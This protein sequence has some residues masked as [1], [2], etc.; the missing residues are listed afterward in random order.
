MLTKPGCPPLLGVSVKS[1]EHPVLTEA[2]AAFME[3]VVREISSDESIEF[4]ILAGLWDNPMDRYFDYA[5]PGSSKSGEDLLREGLARFIGAFRN[6]RKHVV[7]VGD[8]PY[9]RFDPLRVALAKS[10]A[11]RG[12]VFCSLWPKC[13]DLFQGAVAFDYIISP[14][15]GSVQV[16]REMAAISDVRYLNLF[17]R[18]CDV[19]HCMFQRGDHL[20]FLDKSHRGAEFAVEGFNILPAK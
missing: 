7:L 11:L 20:L 1:K 14:D 3:N 12:L 8:S 16:V 10:I 19:A 18:F 13:T 5:T 6:E 4:V 2:C 9:W 17:G 15:P